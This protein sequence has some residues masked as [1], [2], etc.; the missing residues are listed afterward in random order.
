MPPEL[1]L[2]AGGARPAMGI[3]P[4]AWRTPLLQLGL[5]VLALLA[6]TASD[7][8]AMAHQWWAISTYNHILLIPAILAWL[9]WNRRGELARLTPHGW[10]P[11]LVGVAGALFLWLLGTLSGLATA[12][13]LGALGAI[14]LAVLA[15]LGPRVASG[16]L[17]PLGYALF[18]V[19]FG[20]ELVPTLQHVTAEITIALTHLSGIPARIEGV[21]IDT[22]AGL[23]EVAEACSGVEFLVAS[24]ALGVLVAQTCYR[25]WPRRIGFVALSI[26]VPILANG[27]RAWGTIAIAQWRG[28]AFAA[29]FD[30][31]VFGWVFFAVVVV[32]LLALGWRWFDRAPEEPGIDAAALLR[33]P[34]LAALDRFGGNG[35]AVLAGLLTLIAAFA[36]WSQL[37]A[38]VAAP[39]PERV[40]PPAAPGWELTH[41]APDLAWEPRAA[42]ADRRLLARYRDEEGH[43]VDLFVALYASQAEGREAG[44]DGEGAL[45]PGTPW[46]WLSESTGP[47]GSRAETLFALGHIRRRAET[48]YWRPGLLTGS[49]VELKLAVMRDKLLLRARPTATVILSATDRPGVSAAES[50]AAFRRSTGPLSSW[51]DRAGPAR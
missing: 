7:W 23:F 35:R 17:F 28:I 26:A 33:S 39:L 14:H 8:A 36:A 41:T 47:A 30:H 37:A 32:L 4:A 45:E 6:L 13:Q 27:V 20:G 22:P 24:I 34:F 3:I 51:M 2:R 40:V 1:S 50:I 11:G 48:S 16:L 46:R 9:V 43:V 49:T 31:V 25:R 10:W 15:V 12:S 5:A 29:G 44:A 19:P 38:G 18:L 21:F 42:G